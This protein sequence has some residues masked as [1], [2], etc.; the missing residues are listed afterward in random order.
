MEYI[1][2]PKAQTGFTSFPEI[3]GFSSELYC[4]QMWSKLYIHR[5]TYFS[6]RH[7][8]S[9]YLSL[10][11]NHRSKKWSNNDTRCYEALISSV[12]SR[13]RTERKS[14][15][16]FSLTILRQRSSLQIT[17][18]VCVRVHEEQIKKK[19]EETG[20]ERIRM[21]MKKLDCLVSMT[22]RRRGYDRTC[23]VMLSFRSLFLNQFDTLH[24]F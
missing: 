1:H 3:R 21:E 19:T 20:L 7:Y 24:F 17:Q 18:L 12:Q 13:T 23:E 5:A 6:A 2:C 16:R 4:I 14:D 15:P 8:S 22:L 11:S 9:Q 10:R